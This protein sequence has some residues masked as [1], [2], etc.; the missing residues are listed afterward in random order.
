[1]GR[2]L[3]FLTFVLLLVAVATIDG[4][5]PPVVAI[6]AGRLFDSKSGRAAENQIILVEGEK[7][8]AVGAAETVRI[9]TG[10]QVIDLSKATV[11]P[12][13]I[14][15]HTHVFGF[16]LDGLKPGGPPFASAVTACPRSEYG[17][18]TNVLAFDETAP[19]SSRILTAGIPRS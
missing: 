9:P 2:K 18:G 6:R 12:G 7:I 13:L 3:G 8:A 17:T 14:D 15:G 1:M 10:A 16:G 19:A 4:Q 11:L 5:A